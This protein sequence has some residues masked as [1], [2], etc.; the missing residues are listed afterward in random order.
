M[1]ED[2]KGKFNQLLL[3]LANG[4]HIDAPNPKAIDQYFSVLKSYSF[5]QIQ[6]CYEALLAK[7]KPRRK[8]DFPVPMEFAQEIQ[9][10]IK[11]QQPEFSFHCPCCNNKTNSPQLSCKCSQNMCFKCWKCFSHCICVEPTPFDQSDTFKQ[12][13]SSLKKINEK[14]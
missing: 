12:F 4:L 5:S 7:Y 3:D 9:L 1:K 13:K 8:N 6:E 10:A 2:E 14:R 11:N